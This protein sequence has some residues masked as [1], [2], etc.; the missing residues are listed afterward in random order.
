MVSTKLISPTEPVTS[1]GCCLPR[2]KIKLVAS[3]F[4]RVSCLMGLPS[5]DLPIVVIFVDGDFARVLL[6]K[7]KSSRLMGWWAKIQRASGPTSRS[8]LAGIF[9]SEFAAVHLFISRALNSL[10]SKLMIGLLVVPGWVSRKRT[11]MVCF[12]EDT[13]LKAYQG[14]RLMGEFSG[15]MVTT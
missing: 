15:E 10:P 5:M 6:H 13:I 3:G 12:L 9:F 1:G 14:L 4:P 8:A 7:S 11:S 2:M